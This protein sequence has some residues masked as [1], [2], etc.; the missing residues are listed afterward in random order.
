MSILSPRFDGQRVSVAA[1]LKNPSAIK[2]KI[3]DLFADDEIVSTFFSPYGAPVEGGGILHPRL[4]GSDRY[5]ADDVA[6]RAPGDEYQ[7]VRALDP[8]M[9]LAVV[10]DYGGKFVITDEEVHRNDIISLQDKIA[11]LSNTVSRKIQTKAIEAIDAATPDTLAASSAWDHVVIEGPD[12]TITPMSARPLSDFARIKALFMDDRM[13]LKPSTVAVSSTDYTNLVIAYGDKLGDVLASAELALHA[14]PY[15]PVGRVYLA[16]KN[17][18]TGAGKAG[19][20][21]F[22]VPLT[23]DIIDRRETRDK[24]IQAYA[25][26]AFAV[27]KPQAVKVITGTITP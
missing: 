4:K 16:A 15:I 13:G 8:E 7:M 21:G 11:Q 14:N 26:P 25:V 17:E 1:V 18:T 10:N 23:V 9:R 20:I 22:E 19:S 27:D 24:V 12:A 2:T 5:T 6:P 3:A